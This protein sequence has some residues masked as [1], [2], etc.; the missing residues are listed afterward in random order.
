M[1]RLMIITPPAE[2]V[3]SH[4]SSVCII[5]ITGNQLKILILCFQRFTFLW[6]CFWENS[7]HNFRLLLFLRLFLSAFL[8]P[9]PVLSFILCFL[10]LL[11]TCYPSSSYLLTLRVKGIYENP[12]DNIIGVYS[13]TQVH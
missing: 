8:L 7:V 5:I 9:F 6:F 10:Y 4:C 1:L 3:R 11:V 12:L 13:I 2:S